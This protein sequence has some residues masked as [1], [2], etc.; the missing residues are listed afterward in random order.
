MI[1]LCLRWIDGLPFTMVWQGHTARQN[2]SRRNFSIRFWRQCV[3]LF[4]SITAI[5]FLLSTSDRKKFSAARRLATT[6]ANRHTYQTIIKFSASPVP[7]C[8]DLR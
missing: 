4:T 2:I 1:F 3:S 8:V 6:P 7:R 5:V